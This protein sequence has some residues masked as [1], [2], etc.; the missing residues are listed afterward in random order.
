VDGVL[1]FPTTVDLI[2]ALHERGLRTAVISASENA[3]EVLMAAGVL[4]LFDIKVDGT[5]AAHLGLAESPI[6]RSFSKRRDAERV[7]TSWSPTCP[8]SSP[9]RRLGRDPHDGSS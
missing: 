9:A 2:T 4:S 3:T 8:S 1:P 5:D 7:P 6:R